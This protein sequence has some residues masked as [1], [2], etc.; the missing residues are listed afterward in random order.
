MMLKT[1][2]V[3]FINMRF[4]SAGEVLTFGQLIRSLKNDLNST[5]I[6]AW[7]VK[8]YPIG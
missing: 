7:Q 6:S 3:L 2:L 4:E 5:G 8:I 1:Y